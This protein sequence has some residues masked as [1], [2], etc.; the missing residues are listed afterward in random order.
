[1][2]FD[3][4]QGLHALRSVDHLPVSRTD[5]LRNYFIHVI[6]KRFNDICGYLDIFNLIVS[7]IK[8]YF[9]CISL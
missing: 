2:F 8:K 4:R 9:F 1:M 7:K 3:Y 6:C 5:V